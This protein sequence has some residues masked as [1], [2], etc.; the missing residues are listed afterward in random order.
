MRVI[1]LLEQ[2]FW[3]WWIVGMA[4]LRGSLCI[5]SD[6]IM[7]IYLVEESTA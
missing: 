2:A 1:G 4:Y 5:A 7:D 3:S 6:V